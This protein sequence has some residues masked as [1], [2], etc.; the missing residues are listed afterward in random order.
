MKILAGLAAV[1]VHEVAEPLLHKHCAAAAHPIPRLL[2]VGHLANDGRD[3]DR[4]TYRASFRRGGNVILPA[5]LLET[6]SPDAFEFVIAQ[7]LSHIVLRHSGW[8]LVRAGITSFI[9]LGIS[10]TIGAT[11]S[12]AISGVKAS[13]IP[14]LSCALIALPGLLALTIPVRRHQTYEADLFSV[15]IQGKFQGIRDYMDYL[16]K[17]RPQNRST[18]RTKIGFFSSHPTP[19]QRIAYLQH[20]LGLD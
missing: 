13:T 2:V 19:K 20:R 4:E 8:A 12:V 17:L 14:V 16:E 10:C 11:I 5:A 15:R 1:R 7:G 18:G 9:I 3:A 6:L